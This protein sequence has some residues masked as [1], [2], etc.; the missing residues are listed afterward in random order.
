MTSKSRVHSRGTRMPSVEAA[1]AASGLKQCRQAQGQ[2]EDAINGVTK[3]EQQ[4]R[5]NA[6]EVRSELQSCVSRQQEALRCREVW[7]LGQIELLEQLKAETLQQQLHQLHWL[8]GQFDIIAHQLQN[9]NSSND[10]NNQLTS[11]M[12]KL[13]SLSLTPEETPE[14][15]FQADT[16]SLRQA[17]T[18]FG[19]ITAQLVEGMSS[20]IPAH[21]RGQVQTCPIAAKKQKTEVA[22]L[23]DWLLGTR[24]TSSAPIIYQSSKNPQ[25]WLMS[26]K[27]SKTSCPVLASVDFL[28]AWGQLRDLEAWL[29]RDQAPV[30]RERTSSSCSSSSSFSIEKIDESEF[31]VTP[32]EE[33][34]EGGEEEL[35]DWLIT[36]P[37]VAMEAISDAE[38]WRQVLKPFEDGWACTDWLAGSSPPAGD[39][40]SCCQTTKA[41]E[42]ENLGQLKCLKTPPATSPA[43]SPTTPAP[44][45]VAPVTALEAW[46]QQAVPVQQT[47]RANELCSAYSECVCE[48]NCGKEAL[49]VWLLQ[50]DGRDKNGV[51]VVKNAPATEK[52][53][54]TPLKTA[55]PTLHHREQEQ[56]VQAILEAWLHPTKT[57][58]SSSSSS[59]SSCRTPLKALTSSLSGWVAP[60]TEKAS[61]EDHSSDFK[62]SSSLFQC[63]LDPELWVLPG[64]TQTPAPGSGGQPHPAE[65]EDKWLL[66]KRSQAQERLALPTVCD[67]FSCMKVGGDKEKWLHKAPVQM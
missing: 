10:L 20:Q 50:Q 19:S 4:L 31:T 28:Q 34:E 14:M 51:P 30:S 43:S 44:P 47:C 11:C 62:P 64:K 46:L 5:E 40:S 16:R 65:E 23:G 41:L 3:A 2:L 54:P 60:E 27:E 24:P 48:E 55:P 7:L 56:K 6:R 8:R 49:N 58:S 29:L 57:S 52:N 1:A 12:E 67:L 15:S 53:T 33:E 35:N 42:I 63:P 61:R 32:E 39:C 59:S 25:D 26:H 13:S 36:P 37:T 9:S 21:Q 22:A 66:K 18:S 45:A 17:I 38:R